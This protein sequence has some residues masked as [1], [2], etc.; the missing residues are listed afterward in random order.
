MMQEVL[1][2]V[3]EGRAAKLVPMREEFFPALWEAAT[4]KI[5]DYLSYPTDL[6]LEGFSGFIRRL[7]SGSN[8]LVYA[9]HSQESN[10]PIGVTT[11]MDIR[12]EHSGLEIGNTWVAEAYQGTKVN[13]ECKYMLLKHAFE[14]LGAV[15][16]QLKTDARNQQSQRAIEK[17]GAQKEGILRKHVLLS[18]GYIRDSVMYSILADEWPGVKAKLEDRLGYAL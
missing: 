8:I 2:I 14:T 18:S 1:P 3:L 5:F 4:P 17:L 16:V 15:R 11:F 10:L 9:I 6:T 7:M 13:P 12:Q